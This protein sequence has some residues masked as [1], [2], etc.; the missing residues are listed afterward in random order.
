MDQY[1]KCTKMQNP[2]V[3]ATEVEII[4]AA[5]LLCSTIYTFAP[6]GPKC[7]WVWYSPDTFAMICIKMNQFT[8][9]T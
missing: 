2:K 3:W 7:Q 4:A 8:S 5:S 9:L 6:S 1:L